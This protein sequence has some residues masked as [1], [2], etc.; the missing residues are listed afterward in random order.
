VLFSSMAVFPPWP[1]SPAVVSDREGY[2]AFN[3]FPHFLR[4]PPGEYSAT[5]IVDLQA[6]A[7]GELANAYRVTDRLREAEDAFGAA[8]A[9]LKKGTGDGLLRARLLDRHAS[10]LGTL[11]DPLAL[12]SLQVVPDL[13]LE[14][15]ETHLAGRA[16]INKALYTFYSGQ[17]QEAIRLNSQGL[18]LV[19][20]SREPGLGPAAVQ[21]QLLFLTEGGD[22]RRAKRFLF[23]NRS[24]L[25]NIGRMTALR[26][27]WIEGRIEYGVGKPKR[28]EAAFR[29]TREGFEGAS[30]AFAAALVTLDLGLALLRQERADEAEKEVLAASKV[31]V[32]LNINNEIL[33]AVVL[34]EN[35]F[36]LKTA[37]V[38]LMESALHH[39]RWRVIELGLF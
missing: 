18:T 8:F 3:S 1:D 13:Y 6:R 21:N 15:G 29:D 25:L 39:I 31:F 12:Q 2:A 26:L 19:D 14:A 20:V 4:V 37:T 32:S 24:Q 35:A 22:F 11:R 10:L 16:L 30:L 38:S 7:W 33:A 9:L 34:L 28:A 5:Q 27:R 23:E 36:R 17:V